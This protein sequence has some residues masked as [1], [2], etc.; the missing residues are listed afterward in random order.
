MNLRMANL[1]GVSKTY[2][3]GLCAIEFGDAIVT[4]RWRVKV[5]RLPPGEYTA[6]A[7]FADNASRQ[8]AA[9]RGQ[10]GSGQTT[11][12]PPVLLGKFV[13]R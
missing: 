6:E 4:E 3:K 9:P 1:A 5:G 13:V 8:W 2:T 12:S 7:I 11:L 10:P